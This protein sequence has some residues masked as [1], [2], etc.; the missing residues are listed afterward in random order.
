MRGFLTCATVLIATASGISAEPGKLRAEPPVA[1]FELVDG[2][3]NILVMDGSSPMPGVHIRC[4]VG[5]TVWAAG[6][7]D[8]EGRGSFPRPTADWCSLVFDI[9]AGPSVPVPLSFL[10]DNTVVPTTALVRDG[11]AE[12]CI[13][14]T[15]RPVDPSSDYTRNSIP[16]YYQQTLASGLA[17][18]VLGI[19]WAFWRWRRFILARTGSNRSPQHTRSKRT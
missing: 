6:E 5:S 2:W 8:D 14:P 1:R 13:D 15:R 3:L 10:K 18:I 4:L 17:V 9:G 11:T 12:C 7:T 16:W 19:I